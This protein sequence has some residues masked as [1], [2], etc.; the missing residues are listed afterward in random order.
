LFLRAPYVEIRNRRDHVTMSRSRFAVLLC[1]LV[2]V[3]AFFWLAQGGFAL[4]K[5]LIDRFFGPRMIRAEV[6]VQGPAGGVNDFR[7]DRGVIVSATRRSLVL[8]E[9]DGTTVT[10]AVAPRARV[11]GSPSVTD[12]SQLRPPMRVLV[13]RRAN[14]R[15]N[16]I[17]VEGTG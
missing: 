10:I 14:A 3:N 16:L 7:L 11:T 17:Q 15:A 8:S 5:A 4:P 12:V 6:I 1:A 9:Q 13:V 2:A